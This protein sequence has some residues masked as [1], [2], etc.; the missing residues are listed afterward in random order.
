[1]KLLVLYVFHEYN[2]RVEYFFMNAFFQDPNVDFVIISNSLDDKHIPIDLLL[3]YTNIT[4]IKRENNGYDFGGWSEALFKDNLYQK[5]DFFIF[6][7]SSALGPFLPSYYK[8]KWTT[9]FIEGLH[10]NIKLFGSTINTAGYHNQVDPCS[11]AHIQSYIFSMDKET[12][13]YL[14]HC[15]IFSLSNHSDTL[16]DAVYNKEILMS[17][18]IIEKGWN[19][20]CLY[21]YYKHVDFTFQTPLPDDYCFHFLPDIMYPW[22]YNEKVWSLTELVFIKGN[23]VSIA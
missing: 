3:H 17:R 11:W 9:I 21:N 2:E 19:I 16:V 8:E 10:D 6:V 20:G 1:M 4:F 13:T 23:R 7:N 15:E 5:Y 22:Y 12:L 18:K 14:I